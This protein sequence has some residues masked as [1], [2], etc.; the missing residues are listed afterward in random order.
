MEFRRAGCCDVWNPGFLIYL[1][2]IDKIHSGSALCWATGMWVRQTH[3]WE[4]GRE[5]HAYSWTLGWGCSYS[6]SLQE[7]V[8]SRAGPKRIALITDCLGLWIPHRILCGSGH[9]KDGEGNLEILFGSLVAIGICDIWETGT[10][11][12]L[13]TFIRVFWH[14]LPRL[15]AFWPSCE[16]V[17]PEH[18]P[19]ARH[20]PRKAD[21]I[22]KV[23]PFG[24][25]K[26]NQH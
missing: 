14:Q 10:S 3:F 20:C 4:W 12:L 1:S 21:S 24:K 8:F 23:L 17:L 19:W 15:W 26:R 25:R 5:A 13:N 16:E 6:E 9:W 18:Q 2:D 7:E 11:G 22:L